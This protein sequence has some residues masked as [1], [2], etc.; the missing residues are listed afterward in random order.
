MPKAQADGHFSAS[1]QR[2]AIM[3]CPVANP[4]RPFPRCLPIDT[5][6]LPAALLSTLA[7]I[8]AVRGGKAEI[9]L[10]YTT[11]C[12]RCFLA[13]CTLNACFAQARDN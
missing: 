3:H 8:G 9:D 2:T 10:E 13:V 7:A 12:V 4:N 1:V 6:P 5:P 11:N